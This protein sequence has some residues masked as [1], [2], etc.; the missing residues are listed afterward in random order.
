MIYFEILIINESDYKLL[1]KVFKYSF[2]VI[3]AKKIS[4]H[5]EVAK[6]VLLGYQ[7]LNSYVSP[8]K[9]DFQ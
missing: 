5:T 2:L 3:V 9:N 1:N 4:H 6:K 8:R 7:N